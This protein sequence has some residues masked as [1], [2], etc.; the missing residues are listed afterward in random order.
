FATDF[1][2]EFDVASTTNGTSDLIQVNGSVAFNNNTVT[3]NLLSGT[4]AAGT[5][6]LMNYTGSRTGTLNATPVFNPPG[7]SGTISTSTTNQVNLIVTTGGGGSSP[8]VSF[9]SNGDGT[10]TI[11]WTDASFHLQ[12]NSVSVVSSGS[13]FDY[14]GGGSS[15][16]VVPINPASAT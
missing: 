10:L 1:T 7:A 2:P 11:S 13:W 16:V 9:V 3:I 8:T 5:Y 15:P 14:P 4:I 12:S 6:R